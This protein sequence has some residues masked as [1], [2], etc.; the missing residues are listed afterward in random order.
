MGCN[1]NIER[2]TM[3]MFTCMLHS[4]R[5]PRNVCCKYRWMTLVWLVDNYAI[6]KWV[7][8]NYQSYSN[9]SAMHIAK[10][11]TQVSIQINNSHL[12]FKLIIPTCKNNTHSTCCNKT[13]SL[14]CSTPKYATPKSSRLACAITANSKNT[15]HQYICFDTDPG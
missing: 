4:T 15:K 5:L 13:S 2:I 12:K 7:I 3:C 6:I 11:P 10:Y 1:L 14:T 9:S 8:K